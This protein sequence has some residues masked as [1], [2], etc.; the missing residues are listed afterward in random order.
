MAAARR[1]RIECALGA[2][3]AVGAEHS[4]NNRVGRRMFQGI[5]AAIAANALVSERV[6][7]PARDYDASTTDANVGGRRPS[8]LDNQEAAAF[9][10]ESE[11]GGGGGV[12]D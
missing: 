3:R 8:S 9:S 2:S 7:H 6:T 4:H 5:Q 11:G 1:R 12:V 10:F